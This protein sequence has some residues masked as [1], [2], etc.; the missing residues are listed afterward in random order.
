MGNK[1]HSLIESLTRVTPFDVPRDDWRR[2]GAAPN[3]LIPSLD[4]RYR[5]RI[6]ANA[7]MTLRRVRFD[8]IVVTGISGLAMG[9]AIAYEMDKHLVAVRKNR[10]QC[11]SRNS[12][13]NILGDSFTWIFIDDH[14]T[15]G[16]TVER[17]FTSMA[18]SYPHAPC[19]GIFLYDP[20]GRRTGYC[21]SHYGNVRVISSDDFFNPPPPS[22]R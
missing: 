12:I 1:T 19:A 4:P 9:S 6:V 14:I 11:H 17:V 10:E 20:S 7:S 18:R 21:H 2:N 22:L 15:S 5:R 13:E 8:G 3:W 16:E